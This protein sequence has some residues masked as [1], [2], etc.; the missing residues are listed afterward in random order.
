MHSLARGILQTDAHTFDKE[1][2]NSLYH[3][4]LAVPWKPS[5]LVPTRLLKPQK[6][7][8]AKSGEPA[9]VRTEHW[10]ES[11]K[12][13]SKKQ[14]QV[15]EDIVQVDIGTKGSQ[16][17]YTKQNGA[18][19]RARN[20]KEH[21]KEQEAIKART[22]T[23]RRNR[24]E[25]S[26]RAGKCITTQV[27]IETRSLQAANKTIAHGSESESSNSKA[28]PQVK[29]VNTQKYVSRRMARNLQKYATARWAS[30]G[31]RTAK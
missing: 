28:K 13:Y 2:S 4:A 20:S 14:S 30:Q 8:N 19:L 7:D 27:G 9:S 25:A 1:S 6:E 16:P 5:K 12:S 17:T 11:D 29:G 26:P 31:A 15:K 21:A 24:I 22:P 18:S 10:N 3:S 23:L